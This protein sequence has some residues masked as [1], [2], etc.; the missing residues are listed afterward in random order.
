MACREILGFV[1]TAIPSNQGMHAGIYLPNGDTIAIDHMGEGVP[2]IVALLAELAMAEK[3]IFLIEEPENDLHPAALK[4]LLN[5]ILESSQQNQ[6]VV[7]THSNIVLKHLGG[8][9]DSQVIEVSTEP[10]RW[11]PVASARSIEATTAARMKVMRDLGYEF[12]DLELWDG[13][14][15]LEESSAETIITRFLIPWFAPSLRRLKTV[16]A[17]G[18][19]KVTATFT[20]F[21]RLVLFAHLEPAYDRKA[22]VMVD[23]DP[24]GQKAVEK[25]REKYSDWPP[26]KFGCFTK[27]RF[28]HYYPEH[29]RDR[30]DLVDAMA[31][32]PE[33]NEAKRTLLLDVVHWLNEDEARG[34]KALAASAGELIAFLGV[35]DQ[36]MKGH[37]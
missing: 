2:H 31:S 3:K 13:W 14:L 16:S 6:F 36:D 24:E 37:Q 4:A 30:V 29:F 35:V 21:H 15:I 25:L 26:K 12:S 19:A 33:R 9:P 32:G 22:W 20:D 23:G 7:T 17:G 28:E 5:L 27:H 18:A 34:K 8:A 11:P 1:V 10:G